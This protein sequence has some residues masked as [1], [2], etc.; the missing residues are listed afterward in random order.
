M[1]RASGVLFHISSLY[2]E[3]GCG[4]FGKGAYE[5]I[6]FL[7]KC[8]F[9]YWQVLPFGITDKYNSPYMSFSSFGG[10]PNFVD[11]EMLFE[12]GLVTKEELD[13]QKQVSPYLCEFE[14]LEGK[15]FEFLRKA[16]E[17][18]Q[19]K[20][21]IY[22]F[23]GENTYV[24]DFCI[25]MAKKYANDQKCHSEW[26]K[27]E[28]SEKTLFVWQFIQ[29]EFYTQWQ[30]LRE[31]AKR[32]GIGIIGDLPFYVSYDS[33]DLYSFKKDFQLDEDGRMKKVAGVPPD[34]FSAEGQ[35]WG[36]PL[37]DWDE[38]EK[39]GYRY[40]KARLNHVLKLFDGVRIDHFRAL[41]EYWAVPESE[42]TAINGSWQ[43]GPGEKMI[44]VIKE[45][46]G[47]KLIIAEN[48]GIIDDKVNSLLSFS[49]F[50]G[51]EV[52]QFGF[53][54]N[55]GNC[56]LPHNYVR[57]SVAYTGTHDNNTLL[58]F[59]W[60]LDG[61]TRKDVLDYIG[62]SESDWNKCYDKIFRIMLMSS[63]DTVIFP[64]Q[65]LLCYGSDARL[66]T[67]GKADGNW[68]FRITKEQLSGIDTG[69]FLHFNKM[70]S[71]I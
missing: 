8:G 30:K 69:K 31:Y 38:M 16:S 67:P 46:A 70:Y 3:Y 27:E 5:F 28:Y 14:E 24:N 32:N 47:E 60:E 65:D 7:K 54:G 64:L 44:G 40:W 61:N 58:G 50:P 2:G 23:L 29:Y 68:R 66:N 6:D 45:V 63:A 48:L 41:A 53:D 9:S 59:M 62:F 56:H 13:S 43:K 42:K 1:K 17:R 25:F 33:Q 18:W 35:K 11:P 55:S 37:Y 71:R 57:N 21:I 15:R 52:F 12:E 26:T 22:D 51:M 34:Y 19:D 10:N 20:K 39:N 4:T 36:N 49:G